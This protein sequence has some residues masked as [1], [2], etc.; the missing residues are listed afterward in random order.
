LIL[1]ASTEVV[2]ES[3]SLG[4]LS[5]VAVA[6]FVMLLGVLMPTSVTISKEIVWP[7]S[8]DATEQVTVPPVCE[9]PSDSTCIKPRDNVSVISTSTA[10]I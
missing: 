6:V 3:E 2:T 10:A 1:V 5:E 7:A 9:H 8:R 4:A